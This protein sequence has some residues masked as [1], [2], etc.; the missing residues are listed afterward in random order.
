[1]FARKVSMH[2]K[3]G[4]IAKFGP[5]MEKEIIPKL[6]KQ[7]GFQDEITFFVP[8]KDDCFVISLWDKAEN[9]EAYNRGTYPAV[10]KILSTLIEGTP[11]I[12]TY[13]IGHSTYHKLAA[14]V[15][16]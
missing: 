9:A 12:E 14:A 13:E 3:P 6:R 15:A 8:G 10:L 4:S 1:V 16:A 5:L 7:N 2:L 11:K